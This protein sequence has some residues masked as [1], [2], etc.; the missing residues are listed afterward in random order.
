MSRPSETLIMGRDKYSHMYESVGEAKRVSGPDQNERDRQD[1]LLLLLM[2]LPLQVIYPVLSGGSAQR[3]VLVV[4]L[5]LILIIGVW[6]MRGSRKKFLTAAILTLVSL[7]LIWV[8]LWQAASS[9][10]PLGEFCLLLFL[11]LLSERYLALFIRTHLPVYDLLLAAA[12]LFLLI[13]TWFGLG[14]FL[15]SSLYPVSALGIAGGTDLSG[16]LYAG[17][18]IL[19]TNGGGL[20]MSSIPPPLLRVV[21]NL[22]MIGGILL[23]SVIIAKIGAR[24]YKK[25]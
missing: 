20:P 11:L 2:M 6:V 7:E 24:F 16:F 4:F 13:G 8:S 19:T 21:S 10:L 14:L 25:E 12:A 17:M 15:V 22:G 9:L 1:F 18:L 3:P 23:I 5:S